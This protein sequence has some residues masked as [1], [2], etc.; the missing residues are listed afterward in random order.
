MSRNPLAYDTSRTNGD[1]DL[2]WRGLGVM[3]AVALV[4]PAVLV[5][6][7]HP[8][9]AGTAALGLGGTAVALRGVD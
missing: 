7:A 6:L 2:S 3:V 5:A 4:V 9:L 8:V 1:P